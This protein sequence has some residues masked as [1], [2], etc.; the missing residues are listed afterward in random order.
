MSKEDKK[1]EVITLG[2]WD[3]VNDRWAWV[4]EK[5]VLPAEQCD[6][7]KYLCVQNTCF[8]LPKDQYCLVALTKTDCEPPECIPGYHRN[9][10]Y[11]IAETIMAVRVDK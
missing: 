5:Y 10:V 7:S 2:E 1:E 6:K 3:L 8:N 4:D 11:V 9:V